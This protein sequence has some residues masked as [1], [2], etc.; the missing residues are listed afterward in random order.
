MI[1]V[2]G[3]AADRESARGSGAGSYVRGQT[4]RGVNRRRGEERRGQIGVDRAKEVRQKTRRVHPRESLW[5]PA[6][7]ATTDRTGEPPRVL[8]RMRPT[9][10]LANYSDPSRANFN[11]P[12]SRFYSAR[13]C[14][15][16][17]KG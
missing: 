1:D 16:G 15:R 4:S 9:L 6:P 8:A 11:F 2:D 10:S 13:P 5:P 12:L 7:P 14:R 3:G 17:W